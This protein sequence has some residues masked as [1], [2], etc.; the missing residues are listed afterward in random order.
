MVE[1]IRVL[2]DGFN[3][4]CKNIAASYMKV[5]DE[6]MS[7]IRFCTTSKGKLPYLSYIFRKSE[8]LGT[9]FKKVACS[10]TGNL[11]FFEVH[12]VK[13]SKNHSKYQK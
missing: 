11:L 13:E 6:S 1:G 10:V 8:P 3:D 12:R 9:E 4:S 7:I 5:G 2:I